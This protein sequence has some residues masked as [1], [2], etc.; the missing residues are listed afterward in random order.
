MDNRHNDST[1]L[2]KKIAALEEENQL[3][4]NIIHKA[5]IPIFVVDKYHKISHFNEALEELSGFCAA[6]MIG[7]DF[8]WKAFYGQKRPVMADMIIDNAPDDQIISL[9]GPKYKKA[10]SDKKLS[11]ATDFF[12]DLPPHGK[13]LFFTAAAV[14]DTRGEIAGAVETLQDITAEKTREQEVFELYQTYHKVLEFIPYPIILYDANGFVT[15]V[16]PAFSTVFGW[17]LEEIKGAILPFVPEN[18]KEETT[19]MLDRFKEEER[20][21]RYETQRLTK[22]GRRRDVVIWAASHTWY[23]GRPGERFVILRDITEE[24]RLAANNRTIMRISA[25]LPQYP[26]LEDLMD[27]ITREI[28]ELLHTEGAVVLLYDDIKN[29][30]FF[31]GASY[32]D[33]DTEQ[34]ARKI[35]F[36]LDE[37]LAGKVLQTGRPAVDNQADKDLESYPERERKLGYKTR[38]IQCVPI[39]SD[40]R[41]T[42][43]LCAINKKQNPFDDNDMELMTMI[44]GTVGISIENARFSRA[45]KEAYLDVA[46]MNRA[47]DKAINHLSHELKTP[48]AVLTGSLQ[49]LE[50]KLADLPQVKTA[51]TLNR[52]QRN[53]N[54]IIQIQEETADIM[55]NKIYEA[56][57]LLLVMLQTCKDELATVI[58]QHLDEE[59]PMEVVQAVIEKEFGSPALNYR[60]IIFPRAFDTLFENL[61]PAFDFRDLD[62]RI[63]MDENLPK[64]R[65]PKDVLEKTI[66]G[67]VKNSIENTPDHGRIDIFARRKDNGILFGVHDFGVGIET[68]D[69]KRIFEGFF[70][71]QATADYSTKTPFDFN[72]GGKGVD[73]LRMKLFAD[74][75]GFS[76]HMESKRC[77]FLHDNPGEICPGNILQCRFCTDLSDC[78]NSGYSIFTVFFPHEKKFKKKSLTNPNQL[79]YN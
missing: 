46:S 4:K 56:K 41:I 72:A 10:F 47:K 32:D 44:A 50:K 28:K 62:I 13:W 12:P 2:E 42:G 49:I 73:L 8:Q 66:T 25:A 61:K 1:A 43:I 5:P 76:I 29:D 55:D 54:R 15:Y 7:T 71:T 75:L 77:C 74:R 45:L 19:Q 64:I 63:T 6:D 30:L 52:I 34:R 33:S 27:Y 26:E 24:K 48:V 59:D 18:L 58:E 57:D 3:L 67:L 39:R 31:L 53:L 36:A 69:Q 9:Y 70:S 14:T 22:D 68:G 60:D 21:T 37:V 38:S 65:L 11:A 20:L 16:N 23:K 17:T 40:S 79:E 35:R 51:S 78:R